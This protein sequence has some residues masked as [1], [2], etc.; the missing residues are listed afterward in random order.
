M[1]SRL[2]GRLHAGAEERDRQ[3]GEALSMY[4]RKCSSRKRNV[5][6]LNCG[7]T[8]VRAVRYEKKQ[9]TEKEF[10][11]HNPILDGDSMISVNPT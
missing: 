2:R 5:R 6:V 10:V 11:M 9:K 3:R 7:V 8:V 4:Q 1:K